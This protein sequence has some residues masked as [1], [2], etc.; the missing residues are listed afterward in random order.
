M[1]SIGKLKP[2]QAARLCQRQLRPTTLPPPSRRF[3]TSSRRPFKTSSTFFSASQPGTRPPSTPTKALSKATIFFAGIGLLSF[4]GTAAFLQPASLDAALVEQSPASSTTA[5]ADADAETDYDSLPCFRLAEIRQHDGASKHPWVIHGSRVYDITDWI[6]AHPGGDVILRAAGGS[7]DAYWDIFT[8]HKQDY[9]R[10]ILASYLIGR[11][12]EADLSPDGVV[13][14]L[15]QDPFADDPPRH[16]DLITKTEK[17]RNAETPA[18]ALDGSFLTPNDLF[19]VR[20]HM[21][22][23]TVGDGDAGRHTLTVELPDGSARVYTLDELRARFPHRSVTA[24]LQCSGNRRANMSQGSNRKA[25]GLPWDTGAISNATWQGVSLADVL[26]DAGYDATLSAATGQDDEDEVKHVHFAGM[27]AYAASIPIRKA[28]DPHG[29]VLLAWSM[30]GAPLPRDHGFP[31]R[32]VVPG[33]VAARS[34]KW[35]SKITLSDEESTSQWQRRDYKCFGPNQTTVDWDTAPAIQ[36]MPVQSAITAVKL[37]EARAPTGQENTPRRDG[38]A[39]SLGGYAYSGG[40]RAIVRVD[41]SL[42]DGATWSQA[43]LLPDCAGPSSQCTGHA[44][45][46]WK[47]WRFSGVIPSDAFKPSA[48]TEDGSRKC[49]NLVVKATDESYNTQ[50]ESHAATWNLRGNLAT[51]WHRVQVCS[52]CQPGLQKTIPPPPPPSEGK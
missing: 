23:P 41:V 38:R 46:A 14:D 25:N 3:N 48:A 21:W 27:E 17:P 18:Y 34:V 13:A 39:V 49:T 22:V 51:A 31:L 40:G 44:A 36:E 9:V 8:I 10:D 16:A 24:V 35:L 47:R 26:A 20:N 50:P 6:P 19:Y 42:D 30:N 33:H 2:Q 15:V 11:V 4:A 32:S 29:D 12:H 45:W 52:D 37:H 43:H 5:D 1:S 7:I 28:L